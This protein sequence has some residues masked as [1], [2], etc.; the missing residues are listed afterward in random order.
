MK[1]IY[2]TETGQQALAFSDWVM[3]P[4]EKKGD[5]LEGIPRAGTL[6]NEVGLLFGVPKR[7]RP[8]R[9]GFGL[10]GLVHRRRLGVF[11]VQSSEKRG[12]SRLLRVIYAPLVFG[13]TCE[14]LVRWYSHK[15]FPQEA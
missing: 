3:F 8:G 1:H 6:R 7:R 14:R 12:E 5:A 2:M 13:R 11:G 10:F 4:N 15:R 9:S